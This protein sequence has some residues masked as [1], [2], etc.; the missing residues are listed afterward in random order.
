MIAKI[1]EEVGM[2]K[3]GATTYLYNALKT[4]G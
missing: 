4:V 2:S 3:A 1:M